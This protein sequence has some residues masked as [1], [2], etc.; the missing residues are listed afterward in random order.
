VLPL[1][2]LGSAIPRRSKFHRRPG[3]RFPR[4]VQAC[5]RMRWMVC[6]H[7]H[8]WYLRR[9]SSRRH[10]CRRAP[11]RSGR[12]FRA[13]PPSRH[14]RRQPCLRPGRMPDPQRCWCRRFC[15]R[16]RFSRIRSQHRAQAPRSRATPAAW[17]CV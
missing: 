3:R 5:R 11:P 7:R 2:R 12:R 10:R 17:R 13:H 4:P 8:R 15:R 1:L 16:L 14:H 6:R 9:R